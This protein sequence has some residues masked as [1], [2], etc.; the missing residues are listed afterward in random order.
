MARAKKTEETSATATEETVVAEIAAETTETAAETTPAAENI[1]KAIKDIAREMVDET[2]KKAEDQMIN[3]DLPS[4]ETTAAFPLSS[5]D[6]AFAARETE[7]PTAE[8]TQAATD[9]P[10]T[11]EAAA[12]VVAHLMGKLG[13]DELP[14]QEERDDFMKKLRADLDDAGMEALAIIS[15]R[16]DAATTEATAE[17]IIA[18]REPAPQWKETHR[19]VTENSTY[20]VN[21]I[22]IG[23]RAAAWTHPAWDNKEP[24]ILKRVDGQWSYVD[25]DIT[26]PFTGNVHSLAPAAPDRHTHRREP[27]G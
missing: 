1:S 22:E 12:S 15:A 21:V 23:D 2:M 16:P 25:T 8:T 18:S 17:E 4:A 6:S 5:V 11:Q 7:A 26:E 9:V 3:G 20:L 10:T 19:V 27:I 24:P 13:I 14:T